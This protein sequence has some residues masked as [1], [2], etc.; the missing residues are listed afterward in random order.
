[1]HVS[2]S[3]TQTAVNHSH[4]RFVN[5]ERDLAISDC[6]KPAWDAFVQTFESIA[7]SRLVKT[8]RHV[9]DT[10]DRPLPVRDALTSQL[11]RLGDEIVLARTFNVTVGSLYQSLSP[12]QQARADRLLPVLCRDLGLCPCGTC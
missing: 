2:P 6:Q 9:S 1:M 12:R 7:Q 8:A 3:H 5:L 11:Q 10:S 4:Q